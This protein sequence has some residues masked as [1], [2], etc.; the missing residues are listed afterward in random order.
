MKKIKIM[1][2][3]SQLINYL[4]K[5]YNFKTYLEIELE[6]NNNKEDDEK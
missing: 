5:T 4:I 1:E 3:R 6:L 2:D